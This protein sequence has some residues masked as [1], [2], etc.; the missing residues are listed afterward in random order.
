MAISINIEKVPEVYAEV[1]NERKTVPTRKVV[2]EHGKRVSDADRVISSMKKGFVVMFDLKD[3]RQNNMDE[4]KS[5]VMRLKK[6]AGENTYNLAFVDENWLLLIPPS[7]ALED[8]D[9]EYVR[10]R[11]MLV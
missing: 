2:V 11:Q 4:M 9:P 7:A 5:C 8:K 1:Q 3:L 6:A 10:N